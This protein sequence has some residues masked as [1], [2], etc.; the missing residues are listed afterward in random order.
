[1]VEQS[2]GAIE[3]AVS[4]GSFRLLPAQQLLLE[5]EAPVRLGSRA[6]EIL[7]T[8]VGRAGEVVEKNEIIAQVWPDTFIDENTLRVHI[9]GL[10]RALGDGQP[11]RRFLANVPGRGYRFVAPVRRTRQTSST[12]PMAAT[13]AHNLPVSR[14]RAVGRAEVIGALRERMQRQRFVTIVGAGGIGKTTV[15]LAVAEALLPTYRDGVWLVDLASIDE[16]LSIPDALATSLG[17]NTRSGNRMSELVDFLRGKQLLV[18][19]DSCEHV[20]EAAA[21]LADELLTETP[22]VRILATSREALRGAGERVYRL[23]PLESPAA[24]PD[25][26]AA[27]ALAFPAVQLFVERAAATLDGFELSDADANVVADICRKLGGIALAIELAAARID[28]FGLRQLGALLSDQVRILK[29]GKRTAQP[30]H[31]SLAAALDWSYEFLPEHER[32]VLRRLSV[33]AGAFTLDSAIAVAG[34]DDTDIVEAIAN[35]VTKS[36]VSADVTQSVVQYRL[37]DSTRSYA[38]QKLVASGELDVYVQRHAQHHRD[39]LRRVTLEWEM[40]RTWPEDY[41]RRIDDVRSALSW[42]FS[43][44]GDAAVGVALTVASIPLWLELSLIQEC[45]ERIERALA[46][47]SA[48]PKYGEHDALQLR[49]EL[50]LVALHAGH[51]LPGDFW[52]QTLAL[53]KKLADPPV[54]SR[55]LFHWSCYHFYNGNFREALS[56][57]QKC[58]AFAAENCLVD[59]EML[60]D[61]LVGAVLHYLGD[62]IAAQQRL[63]PI[64]DQP[65]DPAQRGRIAARL[66]ARP[67]HTS[68]LWVRGFPDQAVRAARSAIDEAETFNNALML[69]SIVAQICPIALQV[70]DLAEAEHLIARLLNSSAKHALSSWNALAQCLNGTLLIAHGNRAGL[71]V[72]RVGLERL[73]E[74]GFTFR[75]TISLAALARGLGVFG[76]V[77]EAKQTID[78]ALERASRQDERWCLP[79]LLRIKGEIELLDGLGDAKGKAE[80]CFL[81][82]LDEARRQKAL[83]W[84]LR[85]ATSLAR[86][87]RQ[88]GKNA[89]AKELLSS[90]YDR[91]TEGFGTADLKAARALIDELHA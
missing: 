30:R 62:H 66:I 34:D 72:L 48:Q 37:L 44:K 64:V 25:L 81:E 70:G 50:G 16:P 51:P 55:T 82:A 58:S 86:L 5:N 17:L 57:A 65:I 56:A 67:R 46:S 10:R 42:A 53:A 13:A 27:A 84:E 77:A 31:Q 75:F 39:L 1:M 7:T 85:A 79:E 38:T 91:F 11:G 32:L 73:R 29:Y 28:A 24:S 76:Q 8:L 22:G 21:S 36:L 83:S 78:Q 12:I 45:Y 49:T 52:V 6:L 18:V 9:A 20:T 88:D 47:Q 35:L 68:V 87:W 3:Q 74:T 26:S 89:E 41:G 90:V 15:A 54:R 33:F 23:P 2:S 19:L 60:G 59:N 14:A 63:E 61:G 80:D 4:F 43:P 40:R 71:T 69:T